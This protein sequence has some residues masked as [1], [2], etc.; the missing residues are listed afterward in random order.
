MWYY[1]VRKGAMMEDLKIRLRSDYGPGVPDKSDFK[2][3]VS[4][5]VA[6]VKSALIKALIQ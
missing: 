5:R 2:I 6:A 1:Y 3:F 4:I